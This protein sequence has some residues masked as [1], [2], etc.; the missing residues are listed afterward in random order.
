M[1]PVARSTIART[2]Y[3]REMLLQ[4]NLLREC[5]GLPSEP[6]I[7]DDRLAAVARWQSSCQ[8]DARAATYYLD[9]TLRSALGIGVTLVGLTVPLVGGTVALIGRAIRLVG[10][11]IR[12]IG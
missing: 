6:G 8:E 4:R 5:L 3:E 1:T 9:A 11:A 7:C 12:L 10:R 2:H